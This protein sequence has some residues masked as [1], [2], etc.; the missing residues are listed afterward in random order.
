MTWGK[1]VSSILV[2]CGDRAG[3]EAHYLPPLRAAG[4]AGGLELV[5]PGGPLPAL[6]GVA[7]L[8]LCGGD[9]IHPRNWDPLESLHP[10]A[11]PDE[12]R[13]AFELPLLR[14]AWA[15][16]LPI[17]GICRGEQI[18]NVALGGSLFQH[19]PEACGPAGLPHR[20]GSSSE[21]PQRL[22]HEVVLAPGSR[23]AG[24]LGAARVAVNSRHHQAVR[25]LAPG[26]RAAAWAA[27]TAHAE[28]P[29]VEALEAEDPGRWAFGV[30]W[31][32]E[33]LV[34]RDDAAG[35]AARRLFAAFLAACRG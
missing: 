29:L 22:P 25:R 18:L 8:L 14:A 30:Q 6:E 4:W 15:A 3:A 16:R 32:P 26:L 19:L 33:N 7:G 23:L 17:L 21:R 12:A 13:D 20:Q 34:D 2:A 31:H 11:E 10:E 28:G 24:V 27:E 5:G 35:E 9:D 1:G